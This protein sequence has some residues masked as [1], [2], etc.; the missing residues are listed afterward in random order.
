[1]QRL[2]GCLDARLLRLVRVGEDAV[3]PSAVSSSSICFAYISSET[4]IFFAFTNIC[5]SPVDRPLSW[6]RSERFRTTSA[7]SKMSPVFI[8]SRLCLKRRFQFFGM[9]VPLPVQRLQHE[10]HGLLVDHLSKADFLGVLGGYV[11]GHVVVQDLNRQVL[12]LLAED[13][14]LL[15]FDDRPRAV[16]GVDHLLADLEQPDLPVAPIHQEAGGFVPP[17]SAEKYSESVSKMRPFPGIFVPR[18]ATKSLLRTGSFSDQAA[19]AAARSR[20]APTAWPT[21]SASSN[22]HR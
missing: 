11:H 19:S 22:P 10:L 17:A 1:M 5:F 7:S 8:F 2:R 9:T 16:M 21:V 14:A 18:K 20:A 4:R 6:S 3:E 15:L 12:A 13:G